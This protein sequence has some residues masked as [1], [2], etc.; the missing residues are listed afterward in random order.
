MGLIIYAYPG[1][2]FFPKTSETAHKLQ[3]LRKTQGC[4]W[5][6]GVPSVWAL[7]MNDSYSAGT[8][9][10]ITCFLCTRKRRAY[11]NRS[12]VLPNDPG[13]VDQIGQTIELMM[14]Y[15]CLLVYVALIISLIKNWHYL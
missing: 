1:T 5:A 15:L 11:E 14:K 3:Q 10:L 6:E 4:S 12:H 13:N 7:G 9:Y 8:Q 2:F